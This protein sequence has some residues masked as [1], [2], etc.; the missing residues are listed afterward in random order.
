MVGPDRIM[1]RPITVENLDFNINVF[2]L[3][4]NVISNSLKIQRYHRNQLCTGTGKI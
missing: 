2:E 1:I 4:T 3:L